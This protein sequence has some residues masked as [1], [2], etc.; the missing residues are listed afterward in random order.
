MMQRVARVR[1]RQLK[2][3]VLSGSCGVLQMQSALKQPLRSQIKR[4]MTWAMLLC[5]HWL[6]IYSMAH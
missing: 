2:L 1:E 3:V 6:Y 4:A 5:R